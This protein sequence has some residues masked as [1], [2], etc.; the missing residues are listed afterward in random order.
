MEVTIVDA[1]GR[2]GKMRFEDSGEKNYKVTV[3][4]GTVGLLEVEMTISKE[5][6]KRLAKAS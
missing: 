4:P 6:I 2:R 5:D 3:C 1:N